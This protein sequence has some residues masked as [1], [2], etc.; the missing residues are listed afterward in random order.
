MVSCQKGPTR[1]A[2]AWQVAPFWQNTLDLCVLHDMSIVFY[3]WCGVK[4]FRSCENSSMM[5]A[6]A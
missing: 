5:G 3:G 1:H 6:A 4:I 2:Y